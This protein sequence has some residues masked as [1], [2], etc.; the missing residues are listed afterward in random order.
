MRGEIPKDNAQQN[1]VAG[2]GQKGKDIQI[3]MRIH[4]GFQIS[5]NN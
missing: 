1:Q 5:V 3:S 2:D 4:T